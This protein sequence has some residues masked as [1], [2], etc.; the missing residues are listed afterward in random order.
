MVG[1]QVL[2]KLRLHARVMAVDSQASRFG[3][4]G[5]PSAAPGQQVF[6]L[7]GPAALALASTV[8]AVALH[9]A[10]VVVPALFAL[11]LNGLA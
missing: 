4:T 9:P 10:L 6:E 7:V 8:G 5:G 3:C 1:P 2:L 11:I